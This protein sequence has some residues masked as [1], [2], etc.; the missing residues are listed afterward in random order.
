MKKI[1]LALLTLAL[2]GCGAD[3]APFRPTGNVGL[4]LGADGVS[5]NAS[6]GATNGFL[7]IGANL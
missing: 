5:T 3:G 1:K 6:V 2:A 4:S 7:T